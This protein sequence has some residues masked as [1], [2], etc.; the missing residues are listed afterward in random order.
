[1]ARRPSRP[2]GHSAQRRLPP[3]PV[4]IASGHRRLPTPT[5]GDYS[6]V[7][8]LSQPPIVR[9]HIAARSLITISPSRRLTISRSPRRFLQIR[10]KSCSPS[11]APPLGPR[12]YVANLQPSI[13]REDRAGAEVGRRGAHAGRP[14]RHCHWAPTSRFRAD[15]RYSSGLAEPKQ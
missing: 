11:S 6:A 3:K 8:D 10:A 2:A 13:A 1:S 5:P 9:G 14:V 7:H 12:S 15:C 4:A